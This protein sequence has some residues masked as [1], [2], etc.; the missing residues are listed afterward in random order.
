MVFEFLK[1]MDQDHE[2][3]IKTLTDRLV[4]VEREQVE[5]DKFI[6]LLE[7]ETQ[8]VFRDFTPRKMDNKNLRKIDELKRKKEAL[9]RSKNSI[10]SELSALRSVHKEIRASIQEVKELEIAAEDSRW[11]EENVYDAGNDE[12]PAPEKLSVEMAAKLENILT[13]LLADPM[14]AKTE[15]QKLLS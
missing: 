3:R 11:Y 5:N 6:A 14:R 8:K 12:E 13:F 7:S 9:D 4:E 15:L 1:K 2:S 10:E